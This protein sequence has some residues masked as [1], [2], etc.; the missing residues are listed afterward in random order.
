MASADAP[1]MSLLSL[2][3]EL[4][5][6]I[7][8]GVFDCPVTIPCGHN[9]CQDCLLSTWKDSY[10]CPQCR[11]VFAT[12]PELKKNTVLSTVAET[13]RARSEAVTADAQIKL[14]KKVE[15]IRCDTCMEAEA[16]HTC[17]TCM[18]SYCEEHLRPHRDNP[19]FRLHQ[20]SRPVGDLAERICSDHHKLMELFCSQHDRSICSLCLQ[21]DHKGCSFTSQE[22]QRSLKESDFRGKL[23]SL[24]EKILKTNTVLNQMS[25]AQSQLKEAANEKKKALAAVYQQIQDMLSQDER[26]AQREVDRELETGEKKLQE[27]MTMLSKNCEKMAKA[28]ETITGLLGL[29]QN[30]SFLQASFELPKAAKT[31]PHVPRIN[32]D[33][34]KVKASQAFAS[35]LKENLTEILKQ[36]FEARSALLKPGEKASNLS[37]SPK[38]KSTPPKSKPEAVKTPQRNRARSKSPGRPLIQP[39]LQPHASFGQPPVVFMG[40]YF[41]GPL[42]GER[43]QPPAVF[44]AVEP[45][46]PQEYGMPWNPFQ[47]KVPPP[48]GQRIKPPKPT[49]EDK[50]S[51]GRNRFRTSAAE[52]RKKAETADAPS[53][54]SSAEKRSELLKHGVMLTFDPDT[55]HQRVMLTDAFTRASLFKEQARYPDRPQRFDV[56]TQVLATESFSQG[57]HYW[58]L[59][60]SSLSFV[61]IGLAYG[62]IDRKGPASRLGRNAQSWCVEW[63]ND[64]TSAWHNGSETLLAS[65][66]PKRVGVLLDCQEGTATFFRVA[67]RAYPFH[68]FVFP[69]TEPVYPAFWI[70]SSDSVI[71]ICKPQSERTERHPGRPLLL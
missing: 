53:D 12:R 5:C 48:P 34:G 45:G 56:C 19:V 11:T 26:E 46:A 47:I 61:G 67:D 1:E 69:F 21:Q 60:L 38:T 44:T 70:F 23:T 55:A 29:S 13:L 65:V 36:P 41:K 33:S 15:T 24:N 9:F 10:S 6:S 3:D 7:C 68:T 66:T 22:Q 52:P 39:H 14:Q 42:P 62:S 16:S 20:L 35:A 30:M 31:E 58:E 27:V 43:P 49:G 54:F 32:L 18:A 57:R 71:S 28:R 59:Q 50:T 40:P 51:G 37:G 2:E 25:G 4:S 63:F 8:L 64:R 17:L